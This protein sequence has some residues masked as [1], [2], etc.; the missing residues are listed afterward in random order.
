MKY[1]YIY[2]ILIN[3][4]GLLCM[5]A[6]KRKAQKRQWRIPERV[7]FSLAFL[8][9]SLGI[10]WGMRLF[11]HKTKHPTFSFGVPILLC[12]H[13]IMLILLLILFGI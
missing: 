7:L 13:V 6:D 5:H 4:A 3:A 9:G 2:L 1:L 8:G 10:F 12:V 11:R